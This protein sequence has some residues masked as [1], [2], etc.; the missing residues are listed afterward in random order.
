M[1]KYI[2]ISS[3]YKITQSK[4]FYRY[5]FIIVI[6]FN[7]EVEILPQN[8]TTEEVKKIVETLNAGQVPSPDV[9]GECIYEL[10]VYVSSFFILDFNKGRVRKERKTLAYWFPF[11]SRTKMGKKKRK[12]KK[13][14][15]TKSQLSSYAFM[16]K[17]ELLVCMRPFCV[18]WWIIIDY[19][20]QIMILCSNWTI[21]WCICVCLSFR[22]FTL[23][24]I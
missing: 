2:F 15:L 16:N 12:K 20:L 23:E 10:K 14:L 17:N 3:H 6:W 18:L 19:S 9:V 24:I 1:L 11:F 21:I 4:Q 8:G 22:T 7:R 5:L 13:K